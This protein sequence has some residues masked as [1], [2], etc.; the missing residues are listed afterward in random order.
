[1]TGGAIAG[2]KVFNVVSGSDPFRVG[3][4]T[5]A[6]VGSAVVAVAGAGF[7]PPVTLGARDL[8][9]TLGTLFGTSGT[10]SG[11]FVGV[12]F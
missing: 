11:A 3:T 12:V 4:S 1:M 7:F 2:R 8:I 9:E 10:F 6:G 5:G